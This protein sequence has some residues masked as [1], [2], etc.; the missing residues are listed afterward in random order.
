MNSYSIE[1]ELIKSMIVSD[2]KNLN[3][4]SEMKEK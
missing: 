1:I 2:N 3:I 4:K